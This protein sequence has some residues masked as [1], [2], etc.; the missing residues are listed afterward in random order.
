MKYNITL[1]GKIY[2]VDVTESDAV[3]TGI[4]QV[5][6]YA[7]EPAAPAPAAPAAPAAPVVSADGVKIQA[8]MPGS[9]VAVKK[10]VGESVTAGETVIVLE[11][12]KMEN[13]IVAPCDGTVKAVVAPK[14][15]TVNTDDV[16]MI[17]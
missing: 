3:V 8:P 1:N 17:I 14:G 16:L 7:A 2:E 5:P 9:V 10:S 11:A 6:V 4:T 15:A 12:M 13:E